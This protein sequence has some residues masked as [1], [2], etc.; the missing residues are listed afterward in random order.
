[1]A[2]T[3]VPDPQKDHAVAMCRF[4]KECLRAFH[5]LSRQL[6][7]RLGPD[8]AE[9]DMRIGIH[10]GQITGGVL[11]GERSRFQLFGDTMNTAARME[12]S[13]LKGRIHISQE[14]VDLLIAAG[15]TQWMMPR[16]DV[17]VAKGK[18]EMRTYWLTMGA[19]DSGTVV[20][21]SDTGSN[22]DRDDISVTSVSDEQEK[23]KVVQATASK[24]TR[25]VEWNCEV[26]V[27]LLKQVSVVDLGSSL[28]IMCGR[29]V[30]FLIPFLLQI[31]DCGAPQDS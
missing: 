31:T 15:K 4:A 25:L 23:A 29:V 12:Q 13:G 10:S 28:Q 18:G 7:R 17:V 16:D 11:R 24:T 1:M 27:R 3:G 21:G 20:S 8:T 5:K 19:S 2:V 26:L 14:T 22:R 9:L 30:F 6:E